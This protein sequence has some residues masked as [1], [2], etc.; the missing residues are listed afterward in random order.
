MLL[1]R[2]R[3]A[4]GGHHA[5]AVHGGRQFSRI[6]VMKFLTCALALA[7]LV[8]L[9]AHADTGKLL[10]T[11]GVS[12]I[13][14]AAG[15]GL[16]PWAVTGTNAT[17]GEIGASAF[18]TGLRTQDYGLTVSGVALAWNDRLEVSFAQQ[19]FD[20]RSNL[21]PL[22][23]DGLHLKQDI[24]GVKVRLAGDAVLD[25]DTLMPQIA[26]G[27]EFKHSD[28]GA[29]G[30][31]L[32]GPLGAKASGTDFYLSATKLFLAQGILVN[33]TL[34]ATKANQNGLLG[35]GGAQGSGTKLQGEFSLAYLINRKLAV[36][37]EARMKPDNLAD[38]VLGTGALRED[39]WYDA[40]VAWAPSKHFS[41]TLAYVDLGRIAPAVQPR[42]QNGAYL[43]AQLAF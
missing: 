37:I 40:F 38:S 14:G 24:V 21:A 25:S 28:V 22:G 1:R 4:C 9:T 33:A 15:G 36:G 11:G 43:S 16:T 19:D 42:R 6:G 13:D 30:P 29:L 12:S 18:V 2:P 20:T 34:R 27:A 7:A 41:L 3:N 10:L 17:R 35:F 8:P 23:L 32:Y 31:T 5:R 39:D 26:I